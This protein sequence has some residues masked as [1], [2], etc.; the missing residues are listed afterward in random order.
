MAA[1]KEIYMLYRK[2]ANERIKYAQKLLENEKAFT[3]ESDRKV[4][5]DREK[6]DWPANEADARSLWY[7]QVEQSL[8]GEQLRRDTIAKLAKEQ[9]KKNPLRGKKAP[10]EMISLRFERILHAI[11]GSNEEEIEDAFFSA[12]LLYTSP[13]PR[14]KRQSR[15]PSSA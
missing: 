3:F 15:M 12:C 6:T 8:L 13:S 2:R 5:I 11:N 1:A 10:G 14:D 9:G 7:N 4:L